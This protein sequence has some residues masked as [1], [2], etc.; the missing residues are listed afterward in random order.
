MAEPAAA[1]VRL[2]DLPTRLTH[3]ALAALV[4]VSWFTAETERMSLHR[5]SG[6]AVL[7]L[8]L[9]RIFWGFAGGSTARFT[10]FVKGP[11]RTLDYLRT[12][13]HRAPS[14]VPGHNPLGAWSVLAMLLFLAVQAG[15]GLFAID[16]D[17]LESGPLSHFVSFEDGRIYA[18]RH[19]QVFN[20][21]LVLIGLHIAAVV[22]YLVYKRD[23]LIGPMI[24]G[25]RRFETPP[26]ALRFAPLW[27]AVL[28][29]ILAAALVWWI[30]QGLRF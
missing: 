15:L 17:G 6:Y 2:W 16:I 12:L 29:A 19:E 30:A 10:S 26:P 22:F 9:F 23:N 28:G 24:G 1:R 4:G 11:R 18:E 13:G 21:L 8:V 25:A 7:A 5:L 14:A 20:I 27:R 3:W